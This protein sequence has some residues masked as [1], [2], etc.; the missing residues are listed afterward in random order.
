MKE[1]PKSAW[2]ALLLLG[3][4]MTYLSSI[5][6]GLTI[7]RQHVFNRTGLS[8]KA[9]VYDYLSSL[10]LQMTRRGW[11]Q[12]EHIVAVLNMQAT[13]I[14]WWSDRYASPA[15]QFCT[16]FFLRHHRCG[17]LQSINWDGL[18]KTRGSVAQP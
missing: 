10:L 13:R 5:P 14:V 11:S 2:S 8:S 18:A 15:V 9:V 12:E 6:F 3:T 4:N 1:W 17:W 16:P 7:F